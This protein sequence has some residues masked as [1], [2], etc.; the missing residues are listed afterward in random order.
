[1]RDRQPR[2]RFCCRRPACSSRRPADLRRGRM[3]RSPSDHRRFFRWTNSL[4]RFYHHSYLHRSWMRNS[5]RSAFRRSFRHSDCRAAVYWRRGYRS[6]AL[7]RQSLW[8]VPYRQPASFLT[9]PSSPSCRQPSLRLEPP[10]QPQSSCPNR[11]RSESSDD[12]TWLLWRGEHHRD[13]LH[14]LSRLRASSVL[15]L[16]RR[17]R[18]A[19]R[20]L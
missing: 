8:R 19:R 7:R 11:S 17:R 1:M 12:L 6:L 16:K 4:Y 15:K 14:I 20:S 2:R 5:Y 3:S 18:N 9:V 10:L 13:D